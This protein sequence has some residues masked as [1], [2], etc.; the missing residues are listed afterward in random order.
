MHFD[1]SQHSPNIHR[2]PKARESFLKVLNWLV[3]YGYFS[4]VCWVFLV[5]VST[6]VFRHDYYNKRE[7]LKIH[8][9]DGECFWKAMFPKDF[10]MLAPHILVKLESLIKS[11]K[12]EL[13][14]YLDDARQSVLAIFL[15]AFMLLRIC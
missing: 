11:Y 10:G 3:F 13:V 9:T 4:C 8:D 5:C 15:R 14:N 2:P 1:V 12:N 7:I 6:H